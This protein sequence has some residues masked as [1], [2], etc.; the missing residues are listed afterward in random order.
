MLGSVF[1]YSCFFLSTL[2]YY[3]KAAQIIAAGTALELGPGAW[4]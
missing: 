2:K 3:V 1:L 4:G